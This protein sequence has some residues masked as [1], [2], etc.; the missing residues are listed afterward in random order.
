MIHVDGCNV[1]VEDSINGVILNSPTAGCFLIQVDDT[2]A[3]ITTAV[4]CP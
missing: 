2:G 3:L 1:Y 4:T